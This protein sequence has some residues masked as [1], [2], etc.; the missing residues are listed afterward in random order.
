MM[1]P[2]KER[3]VRTI[4]SRT[5]TEWLD[6]AECL[7]LLAEEEIGR[8][9]VIQGG[10]PTI[11]PVNYQLDGEAIVF[12]TGPGT[13]FDHGLRAPACFEIDHF[14]RAQRSGWSVV[15]TG[16]LREVT[17]YDGKTLERVKALP[18]DP[19]APGDKPYWMRLTF[20]DLTGRRV[21]ARQP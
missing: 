2:D 13:K 18:V 12:R 1:E 9:A 20:A 7:R 19:W 6:R 4:D 8:L 5:G 14:D 11:F 21:G 15:G 16:R 10:V 17:P 3:D